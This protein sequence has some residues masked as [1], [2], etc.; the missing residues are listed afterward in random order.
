MS[1]VN[2]IESKFRIIAQLLSPLSEKPSTVI[3]VSSIGVER[4]DEFPFKILNSYKVLDQKYFAEK[5]LVE[6]ANKM[7]VSVLTDSMQVFIAI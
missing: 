4:R 7:G 5:L 3:L 6:R 1:M 2:S